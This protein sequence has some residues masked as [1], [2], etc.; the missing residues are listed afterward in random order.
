MRNVYTE[1]RQSYFSLIAG[2]VVID[3]NIIP[4]YNAQVPITN[5]PINPDNYVYISSIFSSGFNDDRFNYT[6]TAVQITIVT[7]SFNNNSGLV[8][9]DIAGQIFCL[10]YLNPNIQQVQIVNGWVIDTRLGQ[11]IVQNGLTD[12][13]KKVVNRILT[14]RHKVKHEPGCANETGLIYWGVQPNDDDPTDFSN[15]LNQNPELPISIDYGVQAISRFYWL[16]VPATATLKTN[17]MDLHDLGNASTIGESTDLFEIRDIVID[18]VDYTLY[19]T[20]YLTDFNGDE[21][22]VKFS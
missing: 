22:Q 9:D 12:G 18:G 15:S 13:Q 14:F 11:D 6:E 7:K 3:T 21:S 10:V 17:W 8:A 1:L 19:M 2:N 20:N 4:F 16:A 5:P